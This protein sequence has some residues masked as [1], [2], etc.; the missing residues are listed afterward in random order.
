MSYIVISVCLFKGVFKSLPF[1]KWFSLSVIFFLRNIHEMQF[2]G[3][4]NIQIGNPSEYPTKVE[5]RESV[6]H[7]FTEKGILVLPS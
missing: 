2:Y 7:N 3:R 6:H 4:E 1:D 5:T